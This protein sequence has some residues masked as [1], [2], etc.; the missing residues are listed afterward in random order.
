[1]N[2]PNDLRHESK[3]DDLQS[4]WRASETQLK[5]EIEKLRAENDEMKTK[6]AELNEKLKEQ[7]LKEI[8][9]LKTEIKTLQT[10]NC[11]EIKKISKSSGDG[12]SSGVNDCSQ[13]ENVRKF[14]EIDRR[15]SDRVLLG[16][17]VV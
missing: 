11:E 10:S 8:K 1:M 12:D 4:T 2:V 13:L 14:Y 6:Y 7:Q 3:S 16:F 15:L 5:S 17:A 9:D